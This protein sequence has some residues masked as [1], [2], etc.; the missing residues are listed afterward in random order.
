MT[1]GTGAG[2]KKKKARRKKGPG[3]TKS[4]GEK[5]TVDGRSGTGQAVD[6][7]ADDEEE[8]GEGDEGLLE[9]EGKVD[10]VAER[11]NLAYVQSRSLYHFPNGSF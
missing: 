7:G 11:K 6:E 1:T 4:G 10:K 9:D 8:E 5:G 2:V 3:S